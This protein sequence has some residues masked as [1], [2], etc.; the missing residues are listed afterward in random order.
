MGALNS[1]HD[2]FVIV[3]CLANGI[4]VDK[5]NG[6]MRAGNADETGISGTKAPN[7][8]SKKKVMM[9]SNVSARALTKPILNRGISPR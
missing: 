6:R 5:S 4:D 3:M 2:Q 8:T 7:K 1:N 9:P